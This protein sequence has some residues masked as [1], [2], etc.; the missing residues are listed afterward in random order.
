MPSV[1]L[2]DHS[3][4]EQSFISHLVELR[5]RLIHMLIAVGVVIMIL[6][7]FSNSMYTYVAAPLIAQL[8]AGST[9]IA[10]QVISPLLTP[11]K[12]ALVVAI[13]VSM[14]YLLYQLWAFVA[15][16]LY[17]HERRLAIPLLVSSILLFYIGVAFA[18][19]VVFPLIFAFMA[20]TTPDGVAMMTDIAAYLDFVLALFFAFGVAFEIPIATILFVAIGV[21]TPDQLTNKRPYV[22]VIAFIIGMVLTPP[23][24]VSQTLLAMP[25]WLLFELGVFFSRLLLRK[26]SDEGLDSSTLPTTEIQDTTFTTRDTLTEAESGN[27][28][29][30]DFTDETNHTSANTILLDD[31]NKQWQPLTE[32]QM[33]AE[34][35][36]LDAAQLNTDQVPPQ[37]HDAPVQSPARFDA[38]PSFAKARAINS[39]EEKLLRANHLRELHSI[40]AARQVLYE[41]LEE[42]SADQR[43]VARNILQQFDET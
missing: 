3:D 38:S 31:P 29:T 2:P 8:P 43:R 40:F 9:M 32:D 37:T 33:E 23:D 14:P 15:P 5:N 27:T 1:I 11:F 10:T 17:R 36:L 6:L 18:Y 16:G 30:F 26:R 41:V 7:P 20:S 21:V 12:L 25:M 34:M 24:V 28:R 4:T 35:D 39:V 22:I 42:G 13:F 19:Y